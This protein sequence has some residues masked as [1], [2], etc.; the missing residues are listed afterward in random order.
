MKNNYFNTTGLSG[1]D[2][3]L[4]IE[5]AKTQNN[6]V[7]VVFKAKQAALTPIQVLDTIY[8][9]FEDKKKLMLIT[10]IRRAITTLTDNGYLVRTNEQVMERLGKSNYKWRLA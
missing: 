5:A 6:K 7:L 1:N 8:T 9:H 4:A 2:L 10:S 3:T